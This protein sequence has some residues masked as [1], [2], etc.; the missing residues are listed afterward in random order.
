ML[1]LCLSL[2]KAERKREGAGV[3]IGH[4]SPVSS[5]PFPSPMNAWQAVSTLPALREEGSVPSGSFCDVE[6]CA[7]PTGLRRSSSV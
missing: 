1:A 2:A 5:F 6:P 4:Q 3:E 7:A